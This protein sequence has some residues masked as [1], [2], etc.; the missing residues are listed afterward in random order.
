MTPKL[1][2]L[3]Q[4]LDASVYLLVK[5][6]S[7]ALSCLQQGINKV[8]ETQCQAQKLLL[9]GQS[10]GQRLSL[11]S[12]EQYRDT[13]S[14]PLGLRL[15]LHRP[16]LVSKAACSH[17]ENICIGT[18][19]SPPTKGAVPASVSAG[20]RSTAWRGFPSPTVPLPSAWPAG[21]DSRTPLCC[22][23]VHR[24]HPW[25]RALVRPRVDLLG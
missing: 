4:L 8:I 14:K 1:W 24:S 19:F 9:S 20:D 15:R 16:T 23:S 5:N 6:H 21:L 22:Q 11:P 25:L 7:P 13:F 18:G 3:R 10:S 12:E 2:G 17:T